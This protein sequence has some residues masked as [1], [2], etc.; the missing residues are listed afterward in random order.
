M[1]WLPLSEE[2]ERSICTD[3]WT[4][5]QHIRLTVKSERQRVTGRFLA[6]AHPD[7][8]STL[9]SAPCPWRSTSTAH[10]TGLLGPLAAGWLWPVRSPSADQRKGKWDW[11]VHS[12]PAS[13]F[14]ALHDFSLP[15]S[16]GHSLSPQL[17][18]CGASVSL[19]CIWWS[20]KKLSSNFLNLSVPSVL[21]YDLNRLWC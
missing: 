13:C 12:L 17:S 8:L 10:I 18:P 2:W 15:S 21:C 19:P 14:A 9:H 5:L 4:Y 7:L 3:T 16:G 1:Q 6:V 20:V 11:E